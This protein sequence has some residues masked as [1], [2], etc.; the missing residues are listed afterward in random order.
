M[1]RS[2]E[3]LFGMIMGALAHRR[4]WADV[5][6]ANAPAF[7]GRVGWPQ[8]VKNWEEDFRQDCFEMHLYAAY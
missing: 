4:M 6:S 3:K 2:V 7:R 1:H 8:D 5:G